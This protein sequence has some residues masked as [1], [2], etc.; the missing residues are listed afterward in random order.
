M[1][2]DPTLPALPTE[3]DD[4]RLAEIVDR[5]CQRVEAGDEPDPDE[6]LSLHPE[7]AP[8][9]AECL[10]G[11]GVVL[12]L[13][14]ELAVEPDDADFQPRA[15]GD[16]QLLRE[17]GRGGMGI[18]YEARQ[19]SLNR[20]V[21]LK[22]LRTGRHRSPNERQRFTVEAQAAARLQ[23]P[24][25]VPI[26]E[27]G[28][29]EGE[30]FFTMP[31]IAG[32]SLAERLEQGPLPVRETAELLGQIAEAVEHAHRSGV[33]H[34][35]LKPANILLEDGSPRI[36]DFGLA[37]IQGEGSDLTLTGQIMGTPNYMAPEQAAGRVHDIGP[38]TD[39]Y[40]LGA[41]LY[42][43]L[44]GR[45]PF[46]AATITETLQQVREQEPVRPDRLN[47]R[48]PADLATI[49]LKCL[50]K[51]PQRRYASADELAQDV[52]AFLDGRP[53][54]ARPDSLFTRLGRSLRR[55]PHPDVIARRGNVAVGKAWFALLVCLL[56]TLLRWLEVP[57]A[58]TYCL[59]AI[60]GGILV[61]A[62]GPRRDDTLVERQVGGVWLAFLIGCLFTA[63]L[64]YLMGLAPFQLSPLIA[65]L[66]GVALFAMACILSGW[67][68]VG[69]VGCFAASLAMAYTAPFD[70]AILGAV[71]FTALLIPTSRRSHRTG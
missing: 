40:A 70:F 45:P 12:Q 30:A 56:V 2:L 54:R 1:N 61:F 24:G 31:L 21:A 13:Q 10:A 33:L 5:F 11:L 68:Y 3:S 23:H 60:G 26:L 57:A 39:I 18:V 59:L 71:M 52:A 49:C 58:A 34:R 48:I 42:E 64:N 38:A 47:N 35:D 7:L 43:L 62:Q 41:I 37:K 32:P 65:V 44:T 66:A 51:E 19:V 17:I 4:D 15:L 28:E 63:L 27:V 6:L 36:T 46:M 9:L 69:A 16:F 67:F 8:Q 55:D 25:I 29:A 50:Q 14:R 20:I 22:L 53:I